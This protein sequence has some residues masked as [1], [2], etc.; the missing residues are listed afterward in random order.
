M[1]P[2]IITTLLWSYCLIPANK[3]VAQLGENNVN[4]LRILFAVLAMGLFTLFG[5]IHLGSSAFSWFFLSGIIGFGFGDLS[6]FFALPR[7]GSR[8]TLLIVHC[9]AAPIAGIVEWLWLGTTIQPLQILAIVII[10]SGV[11][12]A[13]FPERQKEENKQRHYVSGMLFGLIAAIGQGMGAVLSRKAFSVLDPENLTLSDASISDY[14]FLGTTSGFARLVGGLLIAVGFWFIARFHKAW[15]T[16]PEEAHRHDPAWQKIKNIVLHA[17]TGPVLGIICYQW[18]LAVTPSVI[19]QPIIAMTP[20]V[21]IPMT[22]FIEHD[23]PARHAI[24]GTLIAVGGVVIL[25]FG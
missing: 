5:G 4:V 23:R 19:V 1:L 9:V 15:Q 13:L 8:L 6:I 14:I 12:I 24:I 25:A 11:S 20:L 7:I 10:L 22:W 3:A 18:A 17:S 2:A 21:V 16:P